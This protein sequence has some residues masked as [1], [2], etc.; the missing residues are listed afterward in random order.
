MPALLRSALTPPGSVAEFADHLVVHDLPG[1]PDERRA[2]TVAFASRRIAHLPSPMKVGVT[3]VATVVAVLGRVV[4]G[5]RLAAFLARHPLPL[6]GEYVRL[7][8]SL[9]FAYVWDTWP[10]T[11]PSG[12]PLAASDGASADASEMSTPS[13]E[14]R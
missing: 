10:A 3:A 11:D 12:R 7:V 5:G 6:F 8:R 1:L 4:G 14:R 9:T 13:G 2:E